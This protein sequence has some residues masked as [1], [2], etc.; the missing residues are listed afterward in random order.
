MRWLALVLAAACGAKSPPS[1]PAPSNVPSSESNITRE[2]WVSAGAYVARPSIEIEQFLPDFHE[3]LRWPLEGMNHPSLDPRFPIAQELA[4]GVDWQTLCA[5][6]VQNRTSATQ[7]ELLAYL[8]GWCHV[9]QR[10]VEGACRELQPLLGAFTRGLAPAVRQDLANILADH[11]DADKAEHWLSKH[12]IRDV[13]V[14]DRL[15]ASFVEV[16]T[17]ADAFTINR[18]AIDSAYLATAATKCRRL[19]KRI[20]LGADARLDLSAAFA[21]EELHDLAR[22][23]RHTLGDPVCVRL[24]HKVQCWRSPATECSPYLKDENLPSG[25]FWLLNVYYSWPAQEAGSATWSSLGDNALRALP[26]D[27]AVELFISAYEAS[28]RAY[29]NCRGDRALLVQRA[30]SQLRADPKYAAYEPRLAWLAELCSDPVPENL[31]LRRLQVAPVP[32][33]DPSSVPRPA[34]PT[35]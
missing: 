23:S 10:D 33:P 21:I 13:E 29:K 26:L 15:A 22:P 9:K 5:R 18:R 6:G 2:K 20:V 34:P 32:P 35:P 27:G 7:K 1:L 25:T 31:K 19:V 8:R 12:D 28:V 4:I 3:D 14:L 30:V 11:G 24:E 17:A 16:G